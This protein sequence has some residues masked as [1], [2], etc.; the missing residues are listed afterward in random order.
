MRIS[1]RTALSMGAAVVLLAG[2][3][4]SQ[5]P[6]GALG[7]MQQGHAIAAN[8]DRGRSWMLPEANRE[9]L[10]YVS[11]GSTVYVLAYHSGR[12]VGALGGFFEAAGLCVSV[13]GD[14]FVTDSAKQTVSEFA[15]GHTNVKRK[16]SDSG[17]V[18]VGCAVDRTSGNLAVVNYCGAAAYGSIQCGASDGN[19]IIFRRARGSPRTYST[20]A[21]I[22]YVSCDYDDNQNL[23]VSGRERSAFFHLFEL[24]NG[25]KPFR[26]VTLN[27]TF[28][29]ES[30]IQWDGSHVTV[31][32]TFGR[33]IYEFTIRGRRGTLVGSTPVENSSFSQYWIFGQRVLVPAVTGEFYHYW[34]NVYNYPAGGERRRRHAV[35]ESGPGV[36]VSVAPPR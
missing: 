3:G 25:D 16:F 5:A 8:G 6:V 28:L 23:Y 33:V 32:D 35:T 20:P 18:P 1:A 17:F 4:G 2:C 7:A 24:V 22:G 30:P 15:H 19:V 12:L 13:A 26:S 31:G 27:H 11:G 10:I 36:T 29:G 14:V 21:I 9:D 34:I